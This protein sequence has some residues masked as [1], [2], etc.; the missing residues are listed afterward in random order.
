MFGSLTLTRASEAIR[1]EHRVRLWRRRERGRGVPSLR[2][3]VLNS[4]RGEEVVVVETVER[5]VGRRMMTCRVCGR[6]EVS[7]FREEEVSDDAAG[8]GGCCCL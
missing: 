8:G 3:S 7:C 6:E 2:H 4:E 5:T 1:V